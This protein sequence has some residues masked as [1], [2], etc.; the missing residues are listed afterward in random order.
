M[1]QMFATFA[2]VILIKNREQQSNHVKYI[3]VS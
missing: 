1:G 2:M 3:F